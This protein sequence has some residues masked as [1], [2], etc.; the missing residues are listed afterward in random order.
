MKATTDMTTEMIKAT[1]ERRG[2]RFTGIVQGVGFRPL[3]SVIA[4]ELGLTGFVYNDV[5]GVYAEVQG[6]A[7][8]VAQFTSTLRDR[9]PPLAKLDAVEESVLSLTE[10]QA[11]VIVPS[12]QG[13]EANTLVP[14]DTA[15]CRACL[16]ELQNH[17]DRRYGYTFI[18]C[19]HCGPRY[20]IIKDLPYDRAKTTMDDFPMCPTCRAEYE[21]IKGRRYHAEPNA[22]PV[23]GPQYVLYDAKGNRLSLKETDALAKARQYIGEGKIV[24]LKGVGGYHLVCDGRNQ[25]AIRRLRQR[26]QRPHKPLALMVGSLEAVKEI[27]IFSEGESELL[28]SPARP[29]V[30]LHARDKQPIL[31]WGDIAPYNHRIGVMLPYAPIHFVLLPPEAVW[32]MTSGNRS[33]EPVLFEDERAQKELG[34]IA[35]YFLVHNR[36]I[37]APLDDSVAAV[38]KGEPYWYRRARGY[39]P[40]PLRATLPKGGRKQ[41][42]L[43]LGGDLKNAFALSKG[44]QLIM[45][46]HIG[47]LENEATNLHL[48]HNIER[49]TRLF[50]IN[51]DGIIVDKHPNYFASR[52]GRELGQQ[53]NLP[54][55]AVQHHW[56][57]IAS[58]MAENNL[59]EPVLGIAFDGTGYGDD[60]HIWGGEFLVCDHRSY[61]RVLH[62]AYAPLPGGD[63]VS[64]EPW[65]QALWYV[66]QLYRDGA[67]PAAVQQWREGLP[68]EAAFLEKALRSQL[69]MAKSSGIG[70]LFDAVGS[71]L[72]LG[73]S[74]SF[75]GQIAMALE[76]LAQGEKGKLYEFHYEKDVLDFKPL[77]EMLLDRYE[78]GV[79]RKQ[80]A[81]T[82][83]RTLAYGIT[84]AAEDLRRTYGIRKIVLSGGVFQNRRLLQEIDNMWRNTDIEYYIPRQVPANDGG[85]ALGQLWLGHF[86]FNSLK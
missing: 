59:Q 77:V 47:D 3:V 29:I 67:Y 20:T 86:Y 84:E 26:K 81:A 35:D 53:K 57:H 55:F 18:N 40:L 1:Y 79:S 19:T 48:R 63:M 61:Q 80:L 41:S 65:R 64:K 39:V 27:A 11:F 32:V 70:R 2:I 37:E 54:V 50:D 31:P 5:N 33:G 51:L 82:F 58:V 73:Y 60:G 74:Q 66:T 12:P 13:G 68:K 56:A 44:T 78:N 30:L 28:Q 23:C 25:E 24:A 14:P 46:P 75:E 36:Q 16:E 71:L 17:S 62:L 72:G 4:E 49:F 10:E 7:A 34:H 22:C 85:L 9:L 21:D 76:Q 83:H 15:P 52:L 42:L 38:V 43:A 69:P 45:G 6:I 8:Q